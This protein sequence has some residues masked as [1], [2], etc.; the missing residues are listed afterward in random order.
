[1]ARLKVKQIS[2]F[3][4]A[5]NSLISDGQL[6]VDGSIDSLESQVSS[7][8]ASLDAVDGDLSTDIAAVS[9]GLAAEISTTNSEVI[10]LDAYAD[11]LS[12][13]LDAEIER[14]TNAEAGISDALSAEISTTNSEVVS[15]DTR[16]LGA[17]GD[18]T[19]VSNAVSAIL[20]GSTVD[21]DQFAEVVSY[22]QSLDTADGGALTSA[23]ASIDTRVS[24]NTS[25]DVVLSTALAAEIST[26]NS[27]IIS[28]DEV[29]D[30]L[31]DAN[32]VDTRLSNVEDAL[33]A[34]ISTTNSEVV[35]LDARISNEEQQH[36]E[37]FATLSG[38][39]DAEISTTNSEVISLDAY[40]DDLSADL[41]TEVDRAGSVEDAISADLSDVSVELSSEVASID[42]RFGSADTRFDDAESDIGSLETALDGFAKEAYIHGVFSDIVTGGGA[43]TSVLDT[44]GV[45]LDGAVTATENGTGTVTIDLVNP[46]EGNDDKELEANLVFVTINGQT[47]NHDAIR[48]AGAGQFQVIGSALGFNLE[49]DDVLE[50][51]YIKD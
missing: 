25:S 3:V 5:T 45:Q 39:L 51:K 32:S 37:D 41:S 24:I 35:S 30:T 9:D 11:D 12:A 42:T 46:V 17:E 21:L 33:A 38:D 4:S 36:S 28:I 27:E 19:D 1:M 44:T 48:F 43:T 20:A 29:L 2:D 14:A 13:D 31:G 6:A 22:V 47:V 7:N 18:I 34:E 16:V 40:A 10:S 26:T 49:A 50:F 8:Y 15:L 23:I